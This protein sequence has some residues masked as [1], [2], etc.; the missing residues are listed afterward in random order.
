[1]V[2]LQNNNQLI[3]GNADM[4]SSNR[5]EADR[6]STFNKR[7]IWL[8]LAFTFIA[9]L[10]AAYLFSVQVLDIKHYGKKAKNLPLTKFLT[11]FIFTNNIRTIPLKSW[12]KNFQSL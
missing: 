8:K 12:L 2:L 3:F 6:I 10:L 9:L 4:A 1:M 11:T 7:L 5:K